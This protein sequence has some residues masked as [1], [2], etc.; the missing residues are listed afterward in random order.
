MEQAICSQNL[1]EVGVC[2]GRLQSNLGR[3]IVNSGELNYDR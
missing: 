3:K 1:K 2:A